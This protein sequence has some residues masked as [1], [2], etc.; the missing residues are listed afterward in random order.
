MIGK[1]ISHY[2]ILE[3]LG[4]G[5]MGVVYKAEDLKLG[6]VVALKF[7]PPEWTRNAAA[8]TRFLREAQAAAALSHL[9][10]CTIFEIDEADGRLFI[11]MACIEG[12]SLRDTIES[13]PSSAAEVLDAAIQIAEGL[14]EA[15]EKG[16]I[17]RDI[18]PGNLLVTPK[19]QVK[20]TDFGL[21]KLRGQTQL[22]RDG[23]ALGTVAYMS[24]EQARGGP[25]DHRTDIWSLGVVLYEMAAGTRPFG[26]DHEQA[27]I[28]S[29]LNDKPEQLITLR[30]ELPREL[31]RIV[32]RMLTKSPSSRY[33]DAEQVLSDLRKLKEHP[34]ASTGESVAASYARPSI[35]VLPFINMS[36]DPEQ[37]YF[38][39]GITEEIINVLSHVEGLRVV[40]RTSAFAFKG[41]AEDMREIGRRLDVETLLEGSVRRANGCLRITAQLVAVADGCHLWSE[42]YDRDMEHVF[43]IQDEISQAIVDALEVRLL[44][45]EKAAIEKRRTDDLDAYNY[46]LQGRHFWQKRT[47]RGLNKGIECF[48]KAIERDPGYTLAYAGLADSYSC[49]TAYLLLSREE[50]CPKARQAAA[51]AL[52]LDPELAEGHAAM[53]WILHGCDDDLDGAEREFKQAIVLNPGYAVAHQLYSSLLQD[54][55]RF[56]EAMEEAERALE[57]DPLSIPIA[58]NL[59]ALRSGLGD[60]ET[61]EELNR[62]A[63]EIDP[64]RGQPHA[65]LGVRL[66]KVGRTEEGLAEAERGLELSPDEL[67]VNGF[68]GMCLY[69][70]RQYDKAVS[71]LEKL[72]EAAP[73]SD[74]VH[75]YLGLAYLQKGMYEEALASLRTASEVSGRAEPAS[76]AAIGVTYAKMGRTEQAEE[77]LEHLVELSSETYVSPVELACLCFALGDHDRGFEYLEDARERGDP[78]LAFLKIEPWY[79]DVRSDPRFEALLMKMGLG[80]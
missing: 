60:W 52:E 67:S 77:M 16:I 71:R 45:T 5:G 66:I 54:R 29:I 3:K 22:T 4:E 49:L 7:L 39:D 25:L 59:A 34:G 17:H 38:C 27:V 43:T 46:Y 26:G 62:Q 19:G 69:Y 20:I 57:L 70:T 12:H 44:G 72:A 9:N 2:K 48:E 8:R 28:Y 75:Y 76:D 15:H 78:A 37:E 56:R 41:K 35:A 31:G 40:A 51:R 63:V 80:S 68:Y 79:D 21:A 74:I 11:A 58:H 55:G 14:K 53:A 24:P 23:T 6:R 10:I 47:S 1:N 18:K 13:G 50:A 73:F 33:A 36:A 42:K 61:A 65:L 64:G 30:P 32:H